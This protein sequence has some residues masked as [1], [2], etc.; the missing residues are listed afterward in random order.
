[1]ITHLWYKNFKKAE[2]LRTQLYRV[3]FI[4]L[5]SS[6]LSKIRTLYVDLNGAVADFNERQTSLAIKQG[7]MSYLKK[8]NVTL[9]KYNETNV[10][11]KFLDQN[12]FYEEG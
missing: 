12:L 1:M 6:S 8:M 4:S 5:N 11:V 10:R 9:I 7:W 3:G 2:R